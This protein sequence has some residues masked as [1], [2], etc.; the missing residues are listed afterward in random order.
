VGVSLLARY[1]VAALEQAAV[2]FHHMK[3]VLA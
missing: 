2:A 3:E 1:P